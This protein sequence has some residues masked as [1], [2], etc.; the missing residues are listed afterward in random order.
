MKVRAL[1]TSIFSLAFTAL[2]ILPLQVH[3][4]VIVVQP[5]EP[6]FEGEFS[7]LGPSNQQVA[8]DFQFSQPTTIQSVSWFGR[9]GEP[10]SV[11]NPVSFS[12]RFFANAGMSPE[13]LPL[14]EL[15]VAVDA[16]PT[17]LAFN[18]S[19]WFEYSTNLVPLTLNPG[20]YWLSVL[21]T[22]PQTPT[23]G[24]S[25]WLWGDSGTTGVRAFRNSDSMAWTSSL[26]VNHAFTLT[27]TIIPEPSTM[28]LLGSGL[29]GLA[30]WRWRKTKHQ[31]DAK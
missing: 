3:A 23:F 24:N 1:Q 31:T 4:D 22:D 17:G 21:E 9:Y 16:V 19:P 8:D 11:T 15:N 10:L 25:Q 29:I 2:L 14:Q 27:G 5:L 18:G 30:A 7:N 26:D 6:A 20:A 13:V 12:I 28:L